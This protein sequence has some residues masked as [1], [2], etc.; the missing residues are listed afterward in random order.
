MFKRLMGHHQQPNVRKKS[1]QLHSSRFPE[2]GSAKQHLKLGELHLMMKVRLQH[3][4][5]Y[6]IVQAAP[7]KESLNPKSKP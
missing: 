3:F 2:M 1:N 6:K 4:Y 5:V 7:G